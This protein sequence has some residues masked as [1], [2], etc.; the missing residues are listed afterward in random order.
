MTLKQQ[1]D[2]LR[3]ELDEIRERLNYLDSRCLDIM[4]E[5]SSVIID[6]KKIFFKC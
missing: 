5:L 2:Q 4:L 3:N 1:I 6:L